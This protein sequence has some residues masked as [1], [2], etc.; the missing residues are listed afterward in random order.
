MAVI[1]HGII[2]LGNIANDHIRGLSKL[3]DVEIT[4]IC[5]KDIKLLHQ[6]QAQLGVDTKNCFTDYRELLKSKSVDTVSIC[7]PNWTHY[8]IVVE[9]IDAGKPFIVEKPLCIGTAD[10]AKLC[11]LIAKKPVKHMICFSYRYMPSIRYMRW[12]V[13]SQLLGHIRHVYGQYLQ[14]WGNDL[15]RP[16]TWRFQKDKA[17]YGALG[18]LGSHL[19]DLVHF[20]VGEFSEVCADS[21]IIVSQRRLEHDADSFGDVDVDD[22]IHFLARMDNGA[23]ANFSITRFAYGHRNL[24]RL[25]IYGTKG[26]VIYTQDLIN[27][28]FVDHLYTCIGEVYFKSNTFS[29]VRIPM[30]FHCQQMEAFH[31]M[32]SGSDDGLNA[33]IWD[34]YKCEKVMETLAH[35]ADQRQWKKVTY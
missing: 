35:S 9:A 17:G 3:A 15:N 1:R 23:A 25:E 31:H 5:D 27:G 24:Q 22:F 21:G 14:G 18:D 10:A 12:I 13:Q 32:V 19:I 8:P 28:A 34:G 11:N 26:A 6:R 4:A 29:E 2:G 16:L 20:T 30:E 7:T 33:A